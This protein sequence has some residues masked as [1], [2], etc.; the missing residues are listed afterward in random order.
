MKSCFIRKIQRIH[1]FEPAREL[2]IFE[3]MV[4]RKE[5]GRLRRG[6]HDSNLARLKISSEL[7]NTIDPLTSLT[8]G[9]IS[10]RRKLADTRYVS[11]SLVCLLI[12]NLIIQTDLQSH[13]RD[14]KVEGRD[15]GKR[16]IVEMNHSLTR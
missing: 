13:M 16:S 6:E 12:F 9:F 10:S 15:W 14:G 8:D 4:Y 7:K 5:R 1:K 2:F 11:F 3:T